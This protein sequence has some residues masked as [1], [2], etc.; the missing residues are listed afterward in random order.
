MFKDKEVYLCSHQLNL[1]SLSIF[2]S[3]YLLK[4]VI[5]TTVNGIRLLRDVQVA[6][7]VHGWLFS[8]ESIISFSRLKKEKYLTRANQL[9][10][11]D[12]LPAQITPRRKSRSRKAAILHRG[13]ESA[14]RA[15]QP[16]V[17]SFIALAGV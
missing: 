2:C 4:P 1:V 11:V 6:R 14:V 8:L 16:L 5:L 7:D 9:A 3:S 13:R 15:S 10:A 12:Q 17:L